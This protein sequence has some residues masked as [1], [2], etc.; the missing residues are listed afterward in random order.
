MK[1]K[2]RAGTFETNSS[3][4]HSVSVY[5]ASDWEKFKAGEYV[6]SCY[7]DEFVPIKVYEKMPPDKQEDYW[8]IEQFYDAEEDVETS[9]YTTQHGDR[10]IAVSTYHYG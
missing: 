9:E 10:V 6:Y 4:C 2:V 5:E 8:T 1:V 7:N 3:S